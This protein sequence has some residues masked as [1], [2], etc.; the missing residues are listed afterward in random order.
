MKI[1]WKLIL[2]F[3]I[4]INKTDY[5]SPNSIKRYQK[6]FNNHNL[7]GNLNNNFYN[8][9]YNKNDHYYAKNNNFR[10]D[11]SKNFFINKNFSKKEQ[12]IKIII[13]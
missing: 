12:K 6:T 8:N 4:K 9:Y 7:H 10:F 5:Y 2:N 3:L 13:I 11:Q 1:R